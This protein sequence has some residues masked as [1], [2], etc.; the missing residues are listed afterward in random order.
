PLVIIIVSRAVAHWVRPVARVESHNVVRLNF[1]HRQPPINLAEGRRIP[2]VP[3]RVKGI[4]DA[5]C[6]VAGVGR[7]AQTWHVKMSVL[8]VAAHFGEQLLDELLA[9]GMVNES[10]LEVREDGG[11]ALD[12]QVML[13]LARI[14]WGKGLLCHLSGE[15]TERDRAW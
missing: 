14:K 1:V 5:R 8:K 6:Q 4:R 11:E 15:I 10:G 13:R 2:G 12:W 3:V 7:S 9:A